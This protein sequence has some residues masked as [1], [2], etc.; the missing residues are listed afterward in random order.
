MKKGKPASGKLTGD[1]RSNGLN[2][3]QQQ[4]FTTPLDRCLAP[5]PSNVR[6]DTDLARLQA[7]ADKMMQ[8]DPARYPDHW[9]IFYSLEFLRNGWPWPGVSDV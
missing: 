9:Q 8:S 3:N 2:N 7:H 5:N 6:L 4:H 1:N